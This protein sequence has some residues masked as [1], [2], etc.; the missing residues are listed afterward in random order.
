VQQAD[1]GPLAQKGM[2]SVSEVPLKIDLCPPRSESAFHNGLI[3]QS[4]AFDGYSGWLLH[5]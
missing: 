1:L 2:R 4:I 5:G 3:L